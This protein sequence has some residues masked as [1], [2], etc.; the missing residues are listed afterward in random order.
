VR[1]FIAGQYERRSHDGPSCQAWRTCDDA[2]MMGGIEMAEG[3]PEEMEFIPSSV[4]VG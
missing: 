4:P 1:R 2:V 3:I